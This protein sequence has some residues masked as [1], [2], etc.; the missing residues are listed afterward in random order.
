MHIPEGYSY[1]KR[2]PFGTCAAIVPWNAPLQVLRPAPLH[3]A[4][5]GQHDHNLATRPR[6]RRR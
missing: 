5:K 2:E 1:V 3:R 6:N 4:D